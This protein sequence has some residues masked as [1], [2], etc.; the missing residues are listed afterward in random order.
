V[1]QKQATVTPQLKRPGLD[2]ADIANYRPVSNLSFLSKTVNRLVA[3]Q[4]NGDKR[5]AVV[6]AI[7]LQTLSLN[8]TA[9][10]S[11]IF[12]AADQQRVSLL[13]LLDLSAAFDCY[14]DRRAQ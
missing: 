6:D 14:S 7:C 1:S 13:A 11:D 10:P 5:S 3:E 4:L 12:N 2:A 9:C 8:Y